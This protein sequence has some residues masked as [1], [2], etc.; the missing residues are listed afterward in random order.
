MVPFVIQYGVSKK[1]SNQLDH[2]F[3]SI[4][5]SFTHGQD[6][7]LAQHLM[8]WVGDF[9]IPHVLLYKH[10]EIPQLGLRQPN[11]KLIIC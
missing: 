7:T 4:Y 10:I 6:V 3:I 5:S 2:L 11:P 1:L 8:E 9:T